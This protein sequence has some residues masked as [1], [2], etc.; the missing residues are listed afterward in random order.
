MTMRSDSI[1]ERLA[2]I[3][4]LEHEGLELLPAPV[5]EKLRLPPD[6]LADALSSLGYQGPDHRNTEI[7]DDLYYYRSLGIAAGLSTSGNRAAYV[8]PQ[9]GQAHQQYFTPPWIAQSMLLI[10]ERLYGIRSGKKKL[11]VLD[12]TA[13]SGRLLAPFASV[14]H[15]CV[16]VELD[17]RLKGILT[18]AVGSQGLVREGDILRYADILGGDT[19]HVIA[20]NPPYGLQWQAPKGKYELAKGASIESQS[21]ILEIARNLLRDS[22]G[23]L[24]GVFSGR[25]WETHSKAHAFLNKEFQVIAQLELPQ[26]FRGEYGI[27]V[28]ASLVVAYTK[29]SETQASPAPLTGRWEGTSAQELADAVDMAFRKLDCRIVHYMRQGPTFQWLEAYGE[30]KAPEVPELA[31]AAWP[32]L[33]MEGRIAR[34]GFFPAADMARLWS[35]FLQ[36]APVV[37][38]NESQSTLT[39]PV[40]AYGALPN[41]LTLGVRKAKS[42]LAALGFSVSMSDQDAWHLGLAAKEWAYTQ[43]PIR[44]L[45]PQEYLGYFSERVKALREVVV[46][47][48]GARGKDVR[49]PKGAVYRVASRWERVT[50]D[51]EPEM[52]GEDR[53]YERVEHIDRAYLVLR[54]TP[55]KEEHEAFVAKEPEAEQV[56]AVIDA[57][58]LPQVELAEDNAVV[59]ANWS[60]QVDRVVEI[61]SSRSG[62]LRPYDWQIEDVTRFCLR[63]GVG[64]LDEQ[65]AGKTL[66]MGLWAFAQNRSRVLWVTPAAVVPF[67]LEDL[68]KWGFRVMERVSGT[69]GD[70]GRLT[71]EK[72]TALRL[73]R[74]TYR[75]IWN[76][77]ARCKAQRS[78]EHTSELQSH[79]VCA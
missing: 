35:K 77:R 18:R 40:Q 11:V 52:R 24:I 64:N 6:A 28:N 72:I 60:R 70:R 27:G 8:L 44:P 7:P 51:G 21:A 19:Y 46:P 50:E 42:S 54:F 57:F 43:K 34:K 10:A 58:G 23:L 49:V 65:G 13:G 14:G 75:E 22:D 47:K 78:E 31:S 48:A 56:Q 41:I 32:D 45:T 38:Y 26:P 55:E 71:H 17:S 37:E 2:R 66:Q 12:P 15:I 69:D 53:Q 36:E 29:Y 61:I 74:R 1:L 63:S 16:G 25:F 67:I 62:G 39:D 79:P 30:A 33:S 73:E 76:G 59:W 4:T 20:T 5:V 3:E 9:F 68:L